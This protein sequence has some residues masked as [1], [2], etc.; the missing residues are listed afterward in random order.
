[1]SGSGTSDEGVYTYHDRSLATELEDAGLEVL[2]SLSRELLGHDRAPGELR[3]D[4]GYG[5]HRFARIRISLWLTL[6][7]RTAGCAMISADLG[8]ESTLLVEMMFSTPFGSPAWPHQI[9]CLG[10][11]SAGAL[12]PTSCR[13][14]A[15]SVCE[16]GLDSDVLRTTVFPQMM[17]TAN[18]R[19]VSAVGTFQGEIA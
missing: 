9:R 4:R 5:E 10:C 2:R 13:S 11:K 19:M 15:I 12:R 3:R 14:S 18:A 7:L 1:M 8:G 16:R 6:I 17:G